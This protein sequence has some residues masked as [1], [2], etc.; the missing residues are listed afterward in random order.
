MAPRSTLAA[1]LLVAACSGSVEEKT[2]LDLFTDV[3]A[4]SGIAFEATSGRRPSTQILEVKGGGVALFDHDSD[5]DWDV[6]VPNGA[7]LDEPDRGPGARLFDNR[8][9]LHFADVTEERG[10]EFSRWGMG[11]AVGDADGDGRE[12]LFVAGFGRDALLL[13]EPGGLLEAPEEHG[14]GDSDEWGMAASFG[15]LDLDG[16]LD[17]YVANYLA[18]DPARPPERMSFLGVD[19]FGGPMGL[20]ARADRLYENRGAGRFRDVTEASGCGDVPPSFGLG[21]VI[22]DL[23]LD[24]LQ[25]VFVGNDSMANFLFHNRGEWR[26]EERGEASGAASN[27]DGQ[28][29]AT[30]GIAV[31][32]VDGNAYPDLFTTNFAADTNTLHMGAEGLRFR[33]RTQLFGLG[34]VSRPYLGWSTGAYDFDLDGDEDL[35]VFNGHVY[36]EAICRELVHERLQAPLYF[37]RVGDRF[38][39][40]H[41]EDEAWLA[42][43]TCDRGAA[44][45]DLD[46]DGDVDAVVAELGGPLR[47]LRNETAEGGAHSW[48][49]VELRDTRSANARGL[50]AVVTARAGESVQRRWLYS[51]GGYQSA[52]PPVATFAFPDAAAVRLEVTWPGGER[53][54]AGEFEP[55][56]RIVLER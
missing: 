46:G 13:N 30:M 35:L 4:G 21:V 22:L 32:D 48:L 39:A 34:S 26:F 3:T 50:G 44:F 40:A 36:P 2:S 37:E 1:A 43:R 15:D 20:E 31:A 10:L 17:L 14:L 45:A 47:V 19:V 54:D 55:G 56:R 18:F 6:F 25:D 16:D 41:Q 9:A 49:V 23:D 24:G 42:S 11:V 5:G 8:G 53:V 38:E 29:Q 7:T 27:T 52:S 12:D 51:G 28:T 33:D